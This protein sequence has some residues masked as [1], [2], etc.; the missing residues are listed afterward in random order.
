MKFDT[1]YWHSMDRQAAQNLEVPPSQIGISTNIAKDQLAG[2]KSRVFAGAQA[3]ELGFSSGGKGF[4]SQGATTP[5]MYGKEEREAMKQMAKV[6]KVNLQTHAGVNVMG[7]SGLTQKGFDEESREAA[8]NEIKRAVDF[9]AD[10]AGGG[11]VTVHTAEFPRPIAE[12]YEEFESHPEEKKRAVQYL[13]DKDTGEIIDII[14]KDREIYA[15]EWEEDETGR[16]RRDKKTG[17]RIP[18]W[19]PEKKEFKLTK[20]NYD[21]YVADA[22]KWN[23]EHKAEIEKDPNKE[24]TPAIMMYIDTM[25]M[26]ASY[27]RA[28]GKS[29]EHDFEKHEPQL[30]QLNKALDIYKKIESGVPEEEK[31]EL[32][33]QIPS[34]VS[35]FVPP[36]AKLPSKIIEEQRYHLEK[37]LEHDRDMAVSQIEQSREIEQKIKH[38]Q[39][40]GDYAL[41]KTKDSLARLGIYAMD[42]T[43][44]QKLSKP[45]FISPEN[46][47]VRGPGYGGYGAHPQELKDT[48]LKSREEMAKKLVD[49]RKMNKSQAEELASKH[50]RATFD[51]GHAH[52][53]KKFFKGKPED[54]N[55]WLF[56]QV[57]ELNKADIIG[58]VHLSDN[59]GYYDEHTTPGQADVPLKEF[60]QKMKQAGYKGPMIVEPAH[61]EQQVMLDAWK[62][63][64]SPVYKIDLTSKSW[65]DIQGSYFGK[66]HAPGYLVG[67][68]AVPDIKEW[69]LWSGVPLE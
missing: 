46:I 20:R 34:E 6:N 44:A 30:E 14:K 41:N 47:D 57:D 37:K 9:A 2:L 64:H 51:V 39:P 19:D 52:T 24:R 55:K 61:Q 50:I 33:R 4:L 8:I 36:E 59:F 54:F 27:A 67:E 53:W 22:V 43:N 38:A 12:D 69:T 17:R 16:E 23:E 13:V 1:T 40:M 5:G 11:S 10:V 68:G 35:Q 45:L 42:K 60:V 21:Y 28:Y 48:I 7:T 29:F 56:K 63:L 31:K 15:P 62:T 65:T 26:R 58:K 25:D 3:V 49:E 66:T 32:M 18:K